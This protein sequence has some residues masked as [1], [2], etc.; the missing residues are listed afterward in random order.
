MSKLT[1]RADDDLVS[2]LEAFDTSKS[3]VLREALREYIERH[4]D[5]TASH[6]ADTSVGE[7]ID[8]RCLSNAS[9]R[10]LSNASTVGCQSART[11]RSV[12][13]N[14]RIAPERSV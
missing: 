10:C 6:S 3:E 9:T 7:Q 8:G 4:A 12:I 13:V 5:T 1:F 2:R 11:H 14:R